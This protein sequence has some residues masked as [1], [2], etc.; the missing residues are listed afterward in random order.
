MNV[1][2]SNNGDGWRALGSEWPLQLGEVMFDHTPTEDELLAAFPGRQSWLLSKAQNTQ[3]TLMGESYALAI[4]APVGFTSAGGVLQTFQGDPQ[5]QS[6]LVMT[7]AGYSAAGATPPGFFWV[8][9]D[10]TQVPFILSDL[11]GLAGAMLAQ[12]FTAFRH[13]QTQKAAIRAAT[14]VAAVQGVIW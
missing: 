2:Y 1:A 6:N 4:Q 13:L 14:T 11:K 10:N 8:A 3:L 7:L 12:G 5:S 9:A